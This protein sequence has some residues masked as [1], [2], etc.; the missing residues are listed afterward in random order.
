MELDRAFEFAVILAWR[1]LRK[2]VTPACVRVEYWH[3][4]NSKLDHVTLWADKGKGY[5]D[6]VCDYRTSA[7]EGRPIGMRLWRGHD[8]D[9]L[10]RSLAF[11]MEK[12]DSFTSSSTACDGLVLVYPPG[13]AERAQAATWEAALPA[14]VAA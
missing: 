4:L 8:S 14:T 11:I 12:Q 13:D 3:E 9:Q 2:V 1:D 6:R 10:T 7:S 5:C